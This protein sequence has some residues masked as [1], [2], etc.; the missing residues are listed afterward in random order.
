V[1]EN[2]RGCAD[3]YRLAYDLA[4]GHEARYCERDLVSVEQ[5]ICEA[6]RR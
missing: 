5:F 2:S 6:L 4:R 1:I 3:G